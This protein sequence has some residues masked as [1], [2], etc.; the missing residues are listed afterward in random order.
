M[1][2]TIYFDGGCRGNP[3]DMYGSYLIEL[4]GKEVHR[5]LRF[6]LGHG[7]NNEAE[8]KSL[9]MAIGAL[10][11]L[12]FLGLDASEVE[13]EIFTDSKIVKN[14]VSGQKKDTPRS[15]EKLAR[16]YGDGA[17]EAANRMAALAAQC[18]KPLSL[19]KN[20]KILWNPREF[21]VNRFGH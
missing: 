21:N 10:D 18:I 3:G 2:A 11:G 13:I 6:E 20:F 15:L 19:F 12:G 14:R 5:N 17:I 4:N 1:K 7:T 16:K 9:L 8:F